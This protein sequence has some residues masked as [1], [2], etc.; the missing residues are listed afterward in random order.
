MHS[1]LIKVINQITKLSD[2]GEQLFRDVF[3]PF[4]L[5]KKEFFLR[6]GQRNDKA[7]FIIKGLVRYFVIKNDEESTLEF[8]GEHEFVADHPSFINQGNSIQYIQAIED[9]E[10]LVT[11]YDGLQRIYNELEN[12][13]LIGRIVL[14]QR[15]GAMMNQIFS[16]YMHNPEQRYQYFIEQYGDIVQRIPQYLIAS[17]VGIKPQ[18]LSRIKN[19]IAKRNSG[20]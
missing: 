16:I 5:R 11:S 6:P 14:E 17:Y 19:R 18:S 12:G 1:E 9:C 4:T 8:T 20:S 3:K 15:F 10:L 13:N 7:A 2:H